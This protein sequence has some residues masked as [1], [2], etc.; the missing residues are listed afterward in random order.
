MAWKLKGEFIETCSCNMLCPCWFGVKELMVMDQGWCGGPML[1]RIQEGNS[2]G[3]D[4]G[5]NL[6]IL[7]PFFPGPTLFDGNATAR[8]YI[9][10]GA[11]EDQRKE[12]EPIMQGKI[13]GP[14]EIL[15]SFVSTWLSTQPTKINIQEQDGILEA[16]VGNYGQIKSQRLKNE[17]GQPM[18]M[19]NVGFAVAFQFDN[20]TAELAPSDGTRWS[21]PDLPMQFESKSGVFS[22]FS[23]N[24]A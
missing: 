17:A 5:G 11:T 16:T 20:Q 6:L 3:V 10:D 12:L 4:L 22:T 8:L 18:T 24:V 13:G 21:D 15:A 2:G 9:D 23:W 7:V 1:M 19:Q 14:M